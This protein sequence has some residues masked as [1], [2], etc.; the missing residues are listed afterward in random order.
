MAIDPRISLAIRA[1]D[2]TPAL[3]LFQTALNNAQTRE[4]RGFEEERAALLAPLERENLAARTAA[5]KAGGKQQGEANQQALSS[6]RQQAR[7]AAINETGQRIKPLLESGNPTD[8]ESAKSFLI[9]NIAS[10]QARKDAGEDVDITESTEALNLINSGNVA[11]LLGDINSV[12]QLVLGQ[13]G[14]SRIKPTAS[15]QDFAAAQELNR[16]ARESGDPADI[17]AA[18][19]FSLQAG[20]TKPSAEQKQTQAVS[21][22]QA[23]ADVDI[24]FEERKATVKAKVARASALKTQFS[25]QNKNA[26]RSRIKITG[27]RKLAKT[28]TQGLQ[29]TAKLALGRLLPGIDV[30]DEAALSQGFKSLALDELQ[31]FSGPTTDFEFRVTEDIA[32][33]LG[34]GQSANVAR[35]ASLA[36]ATWFSQRE[37]KQFRD[38]E[39]AGHDTDAFAFDFSEKITPKKG[40]PTYT[41]RDLQDTAVANHLTIDEVIERLK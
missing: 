13:S 41:L 31:K 9:R 40:G 19:Q 25:T 24:A 23:L 18:Q 21:K 36:R 14:G 5:I 15:Q 32:G 38:W 22:A 11:G 35:L 4:L 20:F 34:D 26:A 33:S 28:A 1:P 6:G 7:L 30:A 17:L 3:N 29:G 39:K 12:S 37:A 2:I 8:I 16:I 10:L 27:A